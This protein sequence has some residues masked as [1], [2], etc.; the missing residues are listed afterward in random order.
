MG[1][2]TNTG[3]S[4]WGL[5]IFLVLLFWMFTGGNF[6]F[7][8]GFN[9]CNN[10]NNNCQPSN[11]QIEKQEIIDSARTQ[12][13]VEQT[14]RQTQDAASAGFAAL[15]NKI[16]YYELQ[17]LRDQLSEAKN[18]NLQLE[19]RIY[20]DNK[21]N[22]IE[23]QNISMFNALEQKIAAL[24]C[25]LPKRPPYFAQGYVNSGYPI[26]PGFA[27]FNGAYPANNCNSCGC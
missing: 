11:C 10:W 6:G 2:N 5:I 8:R 12:Y 9:N 27:Y 13:L 15:G 17:N 1:E 22:T 26:P 23:A 20:S 19:N 18:K 7:G 16:D 4:G 14:A 25:E 21:F 3:M 24:G